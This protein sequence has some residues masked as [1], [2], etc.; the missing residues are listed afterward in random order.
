MSHCMNCSQGSNS[1]NVDTMKYIGA[2]ATKTS[3]FTGTCFNCGVKGHSNAYCKIRPW[4]ICDICKNRH[5]TQFHDEAMSLRKASMER[6]NKMANSNKNNK[7]EDEDEDKSPYSKIRSLPKAYTAHLNLE[8]EETDDN[9][10][11]W[12]VA[13]AMD[14]YEKENQL[15]E[16]DLAGFHTNFE[17]KGNKMTLENMI[18]STRM[19]EED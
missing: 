6:R 18:E 3:K 17:I 4:A 14:N 11:Q 5:K 1:L 2:C 16:F 13:E 10:D 8:D 19:I 12:A 9:V 7:K 15:T